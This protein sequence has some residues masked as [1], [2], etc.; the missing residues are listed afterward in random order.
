MKKGPPGQPP[1]NNGPPGQPPVNNGPQYVPCPLDGPLTPPGLR[2]GKPF[3]KISEGDS[4][5]IKI[6]NDSGAPVGVEVRIDGIN[7]FAFSQVPN[8]KKIGRLFVKPGGTPL[9][10][11][12]HFFNGPGGTREFLVMPW[13]NSAQAILGTRDESTIGVVTVSFFSAWVG[14]TP[15]PDEPALR[16]GE[17]ATG[18]GKPTDN[19]THDIVCHFG[20]L[21]SNVTIRYAKPTPPGNLPP[22]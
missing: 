9:I 12:W 21:R 14:D 7:M 4:Y 1:V 16:G 8:Y 3:V 11:G 15:P 2:Q 13:E 6:Y 17:L 20:Q 10:T 19:T 22:P 18:I 5:A